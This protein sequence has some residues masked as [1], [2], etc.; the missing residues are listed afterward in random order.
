MAL[1]LTLLL[2]ALA[3]SSAQRGM[4]PL[5]GTHAPPAQAAPVAE[6]P[7]VELGR[8]AWQRDHE[9]AFAAARE[10]HKPVLI[11]FQEIPG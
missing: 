6:V 3:S 8:V 11:L 2:H 1:D 5:A 4:S 9:R 7:P 10:G